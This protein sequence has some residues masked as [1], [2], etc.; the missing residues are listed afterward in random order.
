MDF[1]RDWLSSFKFRFSSGELLNQPSDYYPY[2]A[3]MTSNAANFY[4]DDKY[5]STVRVPGLVTPSLT[6]EKVRTNNF[7]VDIAVL[8]NRLNYSFDYFHRKTRDILV[9]GDVAYPSVLGAS[10]PLTNAGTMETKGIEMELAWRDRLQNGLRYNVSL[11]LGDSHSKVLYFPSNPTKVVD[12]LYDGSVVGSIWGYVTGGILQEDD[13]EWNA[14]TNRYVFPGPYRNVTYFPGDPWLRDLNGDGLIN[15]GANTADDPGDRKIIGNSVSR[16]R[17][18]VNMNASWKGFDLN[19]LFQGVAQ[20]DLWI[21]STTY[22]GGGTN[23]AGSLWMYNRAWRP[24]RTDAKFPRYRSTAGAPDTQTAWL[25]NGAF[26]RLKQLALGYNVP[27]SI[28]SKMKIG[29]LRITAG[30]YNLFEITQIPKIFDPEQVSDAY[31]QY[32]SISIGAQI[33]F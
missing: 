13:L 9:Q 11:S 19:L 5:V 22:W 31:P 29:Q 25:V 4:I 3:T 16:Y 30:G 32:R 7:G 18:G 12:R 26:L 15:T 17:Y 8:K 1:T 33:T 28:I 10:A 6:F 20:R 2:Q 21:S 24:D 27:S 14:T 23:N